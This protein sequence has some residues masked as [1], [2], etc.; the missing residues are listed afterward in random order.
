MT[1]YGVARATTAYIVDSV[2]E[3]VNRNMSAVDQR[4]LNF[5]DVGRHRR[6]AV[7]QRADVVEGLSLTLATTAGLRWF[8]SIAPKPMDRSSTWRSS[9]SVT[10]APRADLTPIGYGSQCWKL[11]VTP[12]GSVSAG[13]GG[14]IGR[15]GVVLAYRSHSWP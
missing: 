2:P 5:R 6:G 7:E 14:V 11:L 12:S 15:T 8:T 13:P 4:S 10:Q 1:L 3:L 9:Q